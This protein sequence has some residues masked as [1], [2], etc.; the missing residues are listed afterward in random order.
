MTPLRAF[1]VDDEPLAIRR[2]SHALGGMEDIE[3]VGTTTS[4]RASLDAIRSLRPDLLFLDIAMPGLDGFDVVERLDPALAPVVIF[5]TAFDAHAVRAFTVNA[6]DYLL[7]PVTPERL[8][9]SVERARVVIEAR[10]AERR[11][12]ALR[13]TIAALREEMQTSPQDDSLWAHRHRELVR[14]PV[15]AI[16]WAGAE[17]DY[18]RLHS[19]NGGGLMRMTLAALEVRLDPS[20]FIR[21]HRSVLCRKSAIVALR[22]KPTGALIL[23]L[24]GGDQV[25][26]GRHYARGIRDLLRRVDAGET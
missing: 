8:R 16:L 9:E 5:V 17:G 14:V 19:A 11:M 25:P 7:K 12:D 23:S 1:L 22:R 3:L 15:E 20:S 13:D 18:V 6:V 21:V 24:A 2:L 10:H 26:V 4:A